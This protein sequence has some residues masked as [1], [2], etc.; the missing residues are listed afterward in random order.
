MIIGTRPEIIKMSPIIRWCERGSIPYF[1]IHTGQ[2]FSY[3]MD[4]I[5]FDELMLPPAEYNLDVGSGTHAEQTA[6]ILIG[7]EK[8]LQDEKAS[9]IL[10][11][12]D[13]NTVLGG[14][15]AAAK[16]HIPVGH[17]E[18]GLRSF[19][20]SMPEEINRICTDHIS[21]YL[22]A[23]TEKAK[24]YLLN[25]NIPENSIYV[26]GNTIVDAITYYSS[27]VEKPSA[28]QGYQIES[29]K[30]FLLT[31]HRSE[32]VDNPRRLSELLNG[33]DRISS[34]YELPIIFP[35]HPRT[36][37]NIRTFGLHLPENVI[38][39]DPVGYLSF[40]NL[41]AHALLIITDSGGVQEEA[42]ILKVPCVTI[43]EETER[44]ETLSVGSNVLAGIDAERLQNCVQSMIAKNRD[45][46]IPF[47]DGTA[48]KQIVDILRAHSF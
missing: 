11:Q 21:D 15:L 48:G 22:F 39:I 28:I 26:T 18:A 3:N 6:R 29:G 30:Y 37:K 35:I 33:L 9:V 31:A 2:H 41:E 4:A 10:V 13:T 14:A 40:L 25:E 43:R 1:V 23:P 38:C 46:D 16:L 12:G 44:P 34:E 5:F 8:I 32:N 42:C 17:V 36:K 24:T 19:N 7:A 47:G 45:W 20:K 27:F